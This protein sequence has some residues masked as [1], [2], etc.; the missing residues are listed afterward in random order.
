[1]VHYAPLADEII[2]KP[3]P[4]YGYDGAVPRW[5]AVTW[6]IAEG[7][8]DATLGWLCDPA[9]Q[10]SA[11]FVVARDGTLYQLVGLDVPAWC[12][13][14]IASPDLNNPIV[15]QTVAAGLNPNLVSYSI[16][17]IGYTGHGQAGSLTVAQALALQRITAY[18]CNR[19][20]LTVDRTHILGHY[21]WDSVT[22]PN[23]P[24]FAPMEWANWIART[25]ALCALWRG[26]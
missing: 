12:Q 22:R 24:G 5:R 23:C 4:N 9:S 8:L 26:W 18:L 14:H 13:G 15:A 10:A 20:K 17:C 1:M 7:S 6:H 16:E 21:Q 19:S 11:H 2:S 25:R 3:S